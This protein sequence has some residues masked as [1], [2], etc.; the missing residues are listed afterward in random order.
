MGQKTVGVDS[1][2]SISLAYKMKA[3]S[4]V[5]TVDAVPIFTVS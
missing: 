3:Q 1:A 5:I 4:I 2:E